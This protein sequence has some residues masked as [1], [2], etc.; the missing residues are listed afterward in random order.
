MRRTIIGRAV[1]APL[2]LAPLIAEPAL[3][4]PAQPSLQDAAGIHGSG[5]TL[6]ITRLPIHTASGI[7][8]RDVTIELHADA[9]G[10]VTIATDTAGHA[11]LGAAPRPGAA[12]AV[13]ATPPSPGVVQ[14]TQQPSA[15]LVMQHFTAGMYETAGGAVVQVIDR[16]I[17]LVHGVPAWSITTVSGGSALESAIWY[18]GPPYVNPKARRLQNA[19]ITSAA[20]AYGISDAGDG[21]LFGTGSLI[22]A[23]QEGNTLKIVSFRKGCCEDSDT[24]VAQLT[25]T[26]LGR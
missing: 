8:Y 14:L 24:P 19:G 25:F 6:T 2:L 4:Q 16:G 9:Q 7:I 1:A 3:A 21:R 20:Y 12:L 23:V 26:R 13:A 22:G 17:D 10:N 18:S 11:L 5:G 15:P